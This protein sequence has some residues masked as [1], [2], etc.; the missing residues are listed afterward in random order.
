M[1]YNLYASIKTRTP[2]AFREHLVNND[3]IDALQ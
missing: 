3:A 1:W 2:H